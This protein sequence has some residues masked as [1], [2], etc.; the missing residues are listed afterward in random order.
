MLHGYIQ[1]T[2]S[3]W[4]V[5]LPQKDEIFNGF[6]FANS[7]HSVLEDDKSE[8]LFFLSTN[9]LKQKEK[10]WIK[11]FTSIG[12]TMSKMKTSVEK[13]WLGGWYL[14]IYSSASLFKCYSRCE[15]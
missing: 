5:I 1:D 2:N 12:D 8:K 14:N 3:L 7:Y 9:I 11:F 4:S 6:Y 15:G 13:F 10:T